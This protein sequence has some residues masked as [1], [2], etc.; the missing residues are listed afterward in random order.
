MRSVDQQGSEP[1]SE[2]F[3]QR[4]DR[5]CDAFEAAW[6]AGQQPRIDQF[7]ADAPAAEQGRL[8][9]ELLALELEYRHR[10]QE[11]PQAADYLRRF[12]EWAE[13][14]LKLFQT[15][16]PPQEIKG[17][18]TTFHSLP[19]RD[20][21][22]GLLAL[23][24]DFISRETLSRALRARVRADALSLG[25]ILVEQGALNPDA[26]A[27]VEALVHQ[28][29]E[30][31]G[32]DPARSLAALQMPEDVRVEL[33]QLCVPVLPG[34]DS[35]SRPEDGDPSV[36]RSPCLGTPTSAGHR[37]RLLRPHARGGLGEVWVARDEELQ[38]EVALKEIQGRHAD[39]RENRA[40]F[41]REA[42]IT[43][44]LEHPG[45]VPV[46]GLGQYADGRPFYAM[47]LIQ[48]GNLKEAIQHLHQ[49]AANRRDPP[50]R[51]L[52]LRQLLDRFLD[53]CNAIAYA[54]SRGVLHRDLK[55]SNIML[56][57][58]GETLIVDWGLAKPFGRAVGPA[59]GAEEPLRPVLPLGSETVTGEGLGTPQFTSPEQAAG[60]WNQLG[61]A[62]DVYSLGATLY[63]LLTGQAPF[64]DPH[65]VGLQKV[66]RQVQQGE[67]PPPRRINPQVP[68]ALEAICLKAMA[69]RPEARYPT[70]RALGEDVEY[71]LADE[72]VTAYREPW[73]VR[74]RRWRRRHKTLVAAVAVLLLTAVGAVTLGT[75]VLGREQARTR[76]RAQVE[77]LRDASPSA[78]PLL[79][80]NLERCRADALPRL[81][82][83]WEHADL[84]ESQRLR[85]GLALLPVDTE[86]VR[87][88]LLALLMQVED[89][90]EL[91]LI[92]DALLPYQ[93]ELRIGLWHRVKDPATDASQR[94][95]LL[96]ALA[97]FDRD[98]AA[99]PE[100]A[101]QVV[102]HL[103]G[104]NAL[105]LGT[106]EKALEPV[107][108]PLLSPL[109]KAFRDPDRPGARAIA[110]NILAEYAIDQPELLT[111]LLL[112]A[113][114]S[115]YR[116][117]FPRLQ[118]YRERVL[119]LLQQELQK[120]PPPE[121]QW[122]E[123]DTLAQL[124]A[125]AAVSLLQLGQDELVWPLLRHSPDPSR[126]TYLVHALGR[127]GTE[128]EMI[129]RRLEAETEVSA[130]R[131]L[132]LS[133]GEFT[134]AQ[135]PL[136]RRQALVD[137]LLQWYRDDPDPGL[138][139]AVDWL[140]RHGWQGTTARR[141]DWHQQSAL[142]A[143]DQDLAGQPP[144]DRHWYITRQGHTLAVVRGPVQFLMGSP[145][146]E[147][148][149]VEKY[150]R[151]QSTTIPR[152][153][154]I[155][156][157]EVTVEQFRRFLK[158]NPSIGN[159]RDLPTEYCPYE[160]CPVLRVTWYEAA[161]YCNWL[162]QQEG[163]PPDQ[164][165]YPRE[166]IGEGMKLPEDYLQRT[167]YR[168]PT[169]SEWEYACRAGAL[170]SRFYGSSATM[171]KEYAWYQRTPSTEHSWPVGQ[172]KPN[173]LGLFDIYGNAAEWCQ[174]SNRSVVRARKPGLTNEDVEETVLDVRETPHRAV[175]GGSFLR[176]DLVMRS[177]NHHANRPSRLT[178]FVGLRVAR[179]C[180]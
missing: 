64:P 41:V 123:R 55:P 1:P 120:E 75:L 142:N 3:L 141:L 97:A 79:L 31:H 135:L 98:N 87:D 88:P 125:Q 46:Y 10:G 26:H 62:S 174:N 15:A 158:A 63:C 153:F 8:L 23:Q 127:L 150:E 85:V 50:E 59:L 4:V 121:E 109:S 84:S 167:G 54:H 100:M 70:A 83:L 60:Q 58:Y 81:R 132:I 124:Q 173:D 77:A 49:A 17:E 74:L 91:L 147:P 145:T 119:A 138:H 39:K 105:H 131:A 13:L 37:F 126:R 93:A 179:T 80:A 154:A 5:V 110:S 20:L 155:G 157:K 24:I 163:I 22:L 161:Q 108:L 113:N 52:A 94:F 151:L 30:L 171:L 170:T 102:E 162:S 33:Q 111:E 43:G 129:L 99:W 44:S 56:G 134:G 12:P 165:C 96:V 7:L 78:V 144:G 18:T 6:Q 168:L 72:P 9:R 164:W 112:E 34:H 61:P 57:R 172:L 146:Y 117:L 66:L 29:L 107:R 45:I 28:H 140:L 25:Q 53:V 160:D 169:E 139:S 19:D 101:D 68:A 104:A 76:A 21:L 65:E 130:R 36:S 42:E 38:R 40:R 48:G 143:I 2:A 90:Q 137:R 148:G 166:P 67:F 71:W 128:P 149:R 178:G 133:L 11:Q 106:W 122:A 92:R 47:R 86:R 51:T 114:P 180:P 82:E 175:R 159:N 115:Q 176:L 156:T 16:T 177:A 136:A 89:P 118:V 116:R 35:L 27:L 69:L 73:G 32:H 14:V 152:S 103:L 95:R